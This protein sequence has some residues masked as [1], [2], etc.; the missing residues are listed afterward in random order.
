MALN[1]LVMGGFAPAALALLAPPPLGVLPQGAPVRAGAFPRIG[2]VVAGRNEC[3]RR[4]TSPEESWALAALP[5]GKTTAPDAYDAAIHCTARFSSTCFARRI[6]SGGRPA[7]RA[8]SHVVIEDGQLLA[9]LE[10]A[11]R[12]VMLFG[13]GHSD[14]EPVAAV[15]ADL[16]AR[17]AR[18]LTVERVDGEPT[19]KSRLAAALLA[20]GFVIGYKGL[21]SRP[22]AGRSRR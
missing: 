12:S 1:G 15:L 4:R 8:G 9:L 19:A 5:D 16:S 3:L 7:R 10:R 18:P 17:R 2:A 22:I 13:A 20:N 21:T 6:T 14:P 11:G